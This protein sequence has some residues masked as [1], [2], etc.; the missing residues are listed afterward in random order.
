MGLRW[1][2]LSPPPLDSVIDFGFAERILLRRSYFPSKQQRNPISAL[3]RNRVSGT[4]DTDP[5][6]VGVALQA[7][8]V[9]VPVGGFG[10]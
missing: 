9:I 3:R 10:L 5:R 6:A 7:A 4:A 2:A 8:D 1:I